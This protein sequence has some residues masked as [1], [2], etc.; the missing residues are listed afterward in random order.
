MHA[1]TQEDSAARSGTDADYSRIRKDV[2]ESLRRYA[3]QRIPT[4]GFL[5]AVLRNDLRDAHAKADM[6][7][8]AAL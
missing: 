2:I 5:E 6:Q 3:H 8:R 1:A 7:N 4:G